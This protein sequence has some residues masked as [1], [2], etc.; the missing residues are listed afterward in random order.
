M[1]P[2]S[3]ETGTL[4]IAGNVGLSSDGVFIDMVFGLEQLLDFTRLG[5]ELKPLLVDRL[6]DPMASNASLLQ[7]L[8]N[9]AGGL[10]MRSEDVRDLLGR[11][12]L[13]ILRR[14]VLRA[15]VG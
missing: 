1:G 2:D 7:P 14:V 4:P 8:S 3:M 10:L 6:R 9:S 13:P 11:V 5:I 12:V 15:A